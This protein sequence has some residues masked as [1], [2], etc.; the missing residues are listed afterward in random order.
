MRKKFSKLVVMIIFLMSLSGLGAASLSG[1]V[2]NADNGER[3]PFISVI[4]KGTNLGTYTNEEGY[5]I[6]NNVPRGEIEIV[7]VNIG[8]KQKII[9][10]RIKDKT[11]DK[12]IKIELKKSAVQVEGISATAE[13][14]K[15]EINTRE[16]IV[17]NVLQ[18]N[19]DLQ[20]IPQLADADVFRA[21]QVLPGVS[22][23]S[24]FS[25]G[26]YIRGGSPDQNLILLD[27][28]DVYNPNHFGG[29]FSTFNT[30][31]IE[32]VELM[33]GGFPA[34]YGG[35]L[36]SV[37]NVI[38]LDGNRKYHQGVARV[39]L[40]SA[41][42]TLQGP[43]K[44]GK[45]KGS[46]MAS[47]RRTYLE[48]LKSAMNLEMPDYYFYDGHA[49]VNYD[50]NEKDKLNVSTYFGKDKLKMNFGGEMLIEWGNE[51][52]SSQW[53]HIFNP[54]IFSKFTL[55]G[56]HFS[57][58]FDVE[59]SSG[60]K[61]TRS[62]DIYDGTLKGVITYTPSEQHML[63]FGFEAKYNNI[64]FLFETKEVDLDPDTLPDVEVNSNIF[65]LFCQDSWDIGAFWT[66]QPGLR[67]TYCYNESPNLSAS[68]KGQYGRISPRLSLR[69]KLTLNSNIFFN[70]GRYYQ[71][72]T[73]LNPGQST[74][75]DLWFPID[76]NVKPGISDHYIAGYKTQISS[77]FALDFEIYYKTYENLVEYRPE[78][79]YEWNNTTGSLKDV[80]N[81][82]D[83]FSYGADVLLRTEWNG[84][85]G[86]FGY[87]FGITKREIENTNINPETG[88]SEAYHPRYERV[89]QANIVQ[90]YKLSENSGFRV[91]GSNLTIGTTYSYG[92]GQPYWKVEKYYLDP[93]GD[94]KPIYSYRDRIR[95]PAYS[96]FDVSFKF[97]WEFKKWSLEP[98]IQVINLFK[99]RNIWSRNYEPDITGEGTNA[100]IEVKEY[101]TA[102]FPRIPFVGFNIEF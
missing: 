14:H 65:S 18:T 40:I 77:D 24:D 89:H 13:K 10:E 48:L 82:G 67:L 7:F 75:M 102:M 26:L 57:S 22:S 20:S 90:N 98:Y 58:I 56:S 95:L 66:I 28:I 91:L 25:S 3:L 23:L 11:D 79:D 94:P 12:F 93:K 31:A 76:G 17:S 84:L 81:M 54:Q 70:Y 43:W 4:I 36:S 88:E 73:S 87:G 69:R 99:H 1:F 62:N 30:D 49:K 86:F 2:S 85:E 29:I 59:Y 80:Y 37:L 27:D 101:D 51:T 45:Q 72:L 61:F 60:S 16:I 53:V 74:P 9:A 38:N 34:K 96:R 50:I 15:Q 21:I 42:T 46:Y 68:P 6:I 35:R 71:Y 32:N 47:F 44:F 19:E 64:T 55:A 92:S 8:Y 100:T 5:F 33:K 41:N 52:F 97:K 83:G 78:T 39:S 63:D